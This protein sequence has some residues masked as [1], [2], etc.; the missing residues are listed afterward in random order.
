MIGR[1]SGA[2]PLVVVIATLAGLLVVAGCGSGSSDSASS[3]GDLVKTTPEASGPIDSVSWDLPLGEPTSLDPIYAYNYSENTV[4]ANVCE[5]LLR[6][7]PDGDFEPNLAS[8]VDHPSPKEWVYTIRPGVKFFDG[9]PLTAEDVAFNIS[10]NLDPQLASFYGLPWGAAIAGVKVTGPDEVTVTT[11]EP[12]TLVNSMMATGLGTIAS[13]K[14]IESEGKAFGTP[15]GD[16]NCT[17][18]FELDSWKP[19]SSITLTKNPNYW[20]QELEAKADEFKF[21]FITDQTALAN[22]LISGEIDGTYEAPVTAV[23]RLASASNGTLYQGSGTQSLSLI[24]TSLDAPNEDM[25]KALS[26]IIDRDAIAETAFLGTA[27]GIKSYAF[28]GASNYEEEQFQEAYDALPDPGPDAE[29]AKQLVEQSGAGSETLKMVVQTGEPALTQTASAIQ[30]E[31]DQVGIKM[32]VETLPP[33]Q[34]VGLFFDPK[35]RSAYDLILAPTYSDVHDV[36]QFY[37]I[38]F[39]SDSVQNIPGYSNAEADKQIAAG[40]ATDDD[41]ER[42]SAAVAAGK[43]ITDE[44]AAIPL[45]SLNERLFMNSRITGAPAAFPYQYFPWAALVGAS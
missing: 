24:P 33:A 23:D 31:A 12:N 40:V 26:A 44:L 34:F 10:R 39:T 19:G 13:Q 29:T 1:S 45:L 41:Q 42:A 17:G 15:S 22:A 43:P 16:L 38:G 30:D 32:D 7:T 2:N 5:A 28:P 18:P 6:Q 8:K 14:T 20:N 4:L 3:S 35:A 9:S 37:F 25:R 36:L 21:S 11:T 27:T